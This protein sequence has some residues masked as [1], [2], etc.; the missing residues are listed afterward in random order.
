MF[1]RL[2]LLENVKIRL[3]YPVV[4]L[5]VTDE[6]ISKQIDFAINKIITNYIFKIR[7]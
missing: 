5:A 6:M 1:N 7:L 4:D 2:A 3:G